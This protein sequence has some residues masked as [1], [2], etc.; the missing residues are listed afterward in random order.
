M[1]L[2]FI[3][4]KSVIIKAQGLSQPFGYMFPTGREHSLPGQNY[5]IFCWKDGIIIKGAKF[6]VGGKPER[7]CAKVELALL[8]RHEA[9]CSEEA[10]PRKPRRRISDGRSTNWFAAQIPSVN[11][12]SSDTKGREQQFSHHFCAVSSF[13]QNP[14]ILQEGGREEGKAPAMGS[15][16]NLCM[17]HTFC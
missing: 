6:N 15:S 13:P 7:R 3:F 12:E 5:F 10:R 1:R 2:A 16:F 8:V 9:S 11:C 14:A 4:F 17:A